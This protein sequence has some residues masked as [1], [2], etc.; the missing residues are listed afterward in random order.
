MSL[1]FLD[2]DLGVAQVDYQQAWDLQRA[3]H[4]EVASGTR[5]GTVLLLEH[6]SVYTAGARTEAAER[7]VDGTPVIDV[8]R[9]GK[10]TWHGPG[11]LVGYPI[12]QLPEAI[13]VVDYVRRLEQSL[14]EMFAH[15]GLTTDRVPGRSGVWVAAD[16]LRPERKIAAIG[17]RV[18]RRTTMH[19]FAINVDPDLSWFDR[20]IPCGISDAGVTSMAAE[21]DQAPTL[22][23]VAAA[24]RPHLVDLLAFRPY[25]PA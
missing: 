3:L 13:Y 16:R 20:I 23:E 6:D 21:L 5:P 15:F 7:P 4:A 17:V 10:I 11:Q 24:L 14:I 12:V 8:D 1:Q 25:V 18:A 22:A 2:A 9:G 19:G